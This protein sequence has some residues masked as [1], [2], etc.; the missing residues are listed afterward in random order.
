[1]TRQVYHTIGLV[2]SRED[3]MQNV[4]LHF[5]L[6]TKVIGRLQNMKHG[7]CPLTGQPPPPKWTKHVQTLHC[8]SLQLL[9]QAI[10]L[11]P[12][13][14]IFLCAN[15]VTLC[16][17][18][19]K[20]RYCTG[21]HAA[22]HP[23]TQFPPPNPAALCTLSFSSPPSSS[24]PPSPSP[25]PPSP[26]P[27]SLTSTSISPS[28]PPPALCQVYLAHVLKSN[29]CIKGVKNYAQTNSLDPADNNPG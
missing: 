12:V 9:V 27:S 8:L 10:F 26:S 14:A 21:V 18:L 22:S 16:D 13:Q 7:I 19:C 5:I 6:E 4:R 28:L 24:S 23:L 29:P 17:C 3:S 15:T 25:S 11:C 2:I 1:M 20:E